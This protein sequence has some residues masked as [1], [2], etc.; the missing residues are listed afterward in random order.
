MYSVSITGRA[1][2]DLRKLDKQVKTRIT[3]AILALADE[4]RPVG[5]L[6]VQSEEDVWR[7]RVGD[8]RVGYIVSDAAKAI[9]VVRVAHRSEFYS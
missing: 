6:K 5:C 2:R 9:V 4:P 3:K 7:I 1:E 8:W